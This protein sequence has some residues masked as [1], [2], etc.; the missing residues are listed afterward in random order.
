VLAAFSKAEGEGETVRQVRETARAELIE[1][2]T[3]RESKILLCLSSGL[4]N[5]EIARELSISPLTVKRHTVN[6][7]G[8]LLVHSRREA[9]TRA[10]ALGILPPD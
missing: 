1:P 3:E 6:L 10:K 8:K 5:K 4:S 2:L 9:V 7:Y